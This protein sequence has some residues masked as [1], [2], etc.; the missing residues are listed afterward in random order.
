M[1][2]D[3]ERAL[4][5]KKRYGEEPISGGKTELETPKAGTWEKFMELT[6]HPSRQVPAV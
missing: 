4:E 5:A 6:T 3:L 2:P 1:H